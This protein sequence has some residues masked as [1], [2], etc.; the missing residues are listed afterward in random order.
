MRDGCEW[1]DCAKKGGKLKG[2]K[3]PHPFKEAGGGK[4]LK[5][6]RRLKE[7]KKRIPDGKKLLR[8]KETDR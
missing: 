1:K 3:Q 6:R 7:G 5:K 2:R 4:S 8:D